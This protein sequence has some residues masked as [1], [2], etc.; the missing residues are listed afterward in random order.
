[1]SAELLYTS[2]AQGLRHGSRGFCTVLMTEGMPLNVISK[3]ES[4][5]SYRRLYTPDHA[6]S[7]RNPVLY[8]HQ[9]MI[10]AGNTTSVLTRTSAYG[11][12]YSGRQNLI[13]H[14]VTLESNEQS[15]AGPAW[16]MQQSGVMRSRWLGHCETP[17]QGPKI[18]SGNQRSRICSAWKSVAGD[19]GWGGVVA[20]A[21]LQGQEPLWIIYDDSQADR[22]LELIDE[23]IS[24]LSVQDRWKATFS[25]FAVNV[26][27]DVD[28]KVRFV[29]VGTAE[30][31]F[32]ASTDRVIDLTAEPTITTSSQLVK[33]A[34]GQLRETGAATPR[35]VGRRDSH[36]AAEP[37]LAAASWTAEPLVE[38]AP[39]APPPTTPPE[40]PEDAVKSGL[41]SRRSIVLA[42]LGGVVVLGGAWSLARWSAG[43][44]IIPD[45]STVDPAPKENVT[46]LGGQS[47]AD[48]ET[49][50]DEV[51]PE[52]ESLEI[53]ARY[54][55][56][57]LLSLAWPEQDSNFD[58]Q[59]RFQ[60]IVTGKPKGQFDK[61]DLS[62][63]RT[64]ET[65][66]RD[67]TTTLDQVQV[68]WG[69]GALLPIA[70]PQRME[71]TSRPGGGVSQILTLGQIPSL[72]DQLPTC[73]LHLDERLQRVVIQ[74]GL[75]VLHHTDESDSPLNDQRAVME[76]FADILGAVIDKHLVIQEKLR[77]LPEPLQLA[78]RSARKRIGADAA[79]IGNRLIQ[80]LRQDVLPGLAAEQLSESLIAERD[81]SDQA[82]VAEAQTALLRIIKECGAISTASVELQG[83]LDELR[84][85]VHVTLP[86]LRLYDA[87]GKLIHVMLLTVHFG[88]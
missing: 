27:P 59:V 2:A 66:L 30:A 77:Q 76:A 85:G 1:M 29:P 11:M 55:A 19:A 62:Q 80:N 51:P 36:S 41:V 31:K 3:L 39:Q 83:V 38:D 88:W 67:Q 13:S 24:L 57:D 82:L 47:P 68:A 22:L 37:S 46:D 75:Q 42:S 49:T 84:Q 18:P 60:G 5:C 44:P 12:D 7:D 64:P 87:S 4:L 70:K 79:S 45:G 86:E 78:S 6:K 74:G 23:G 35:S 26:L 48:P 10:I 69:D 65:P 73:S 8:S 25:T 17:S 56:A 58:G 54:D 40:L 71:V 50:T 52:T 32:A 15:A 81:R 9:R 53:V 34:R 28:C 43:L 33:Q 61:T 21:C 63:P 20:E 16:L 72:P 14:Q